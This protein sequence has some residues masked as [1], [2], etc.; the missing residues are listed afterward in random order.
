[1]SCPVSRMGTLLMLKDK[2][3][4]EQLRDWSSSTRDAK[5]QQCLT[6]D[7]SNIHYAEFEVKFLPSYFY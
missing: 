6:R 3:C 7:N 5:T 2:M 4:C 1:M